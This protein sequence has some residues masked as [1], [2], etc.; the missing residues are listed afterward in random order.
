MRL[1]CH[2]LL[3]AADSRN[4][5]CLRPQFGGTGVFPNRVIKA[6]TLHERP[7]RMLYCGVNEMDS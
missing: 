3:V 7:E 1:R 4:S 6:Q 2:A 5:N